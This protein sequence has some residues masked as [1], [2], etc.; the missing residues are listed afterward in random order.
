M[1][2]EP[3]TSAASTEHDFTVTPS[4]M[5]VQA[6]QLPVAQPMCVPVR[7]KTSR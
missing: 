7:R 6:P 3:S 1:I 2:V 4:R 5:T